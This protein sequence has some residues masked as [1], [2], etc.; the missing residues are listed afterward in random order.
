MSINSLQEVLN[1]L[2]TESKFE[3]FWK[4]SS[5]TASSNPL[6][7]SG[8]LDLTL[9]RRDSDFCSRQF[10]TWSLMSVEG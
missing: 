4:L 6:S 8:A 3:S 1:L 7:L 2:K 10:G 5:A 9:L